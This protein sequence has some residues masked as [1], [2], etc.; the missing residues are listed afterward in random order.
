V[1]HGEQSPP[2]GISSFPAHHRLR[3]VCRAADR[4][5]E[6]GASRVAGFTSG[7]EQTSGI[8]RTKAFGARSGQDKFA[9]TNSGQRFEQL[10]H[11]RPQ[12][13]QAIRSRDGDD[14]ANPRGPNVLLELDVPIHR[15]HRFEP[16]QH[17]E[18]QQFA[19][20]LRRPT[21]VDDVLHVV[22]G[23]L[24]LERPGDTLIGQQ[25]HAPRSS[26]AQV[27]AQRPPFPG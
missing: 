4:G 3:A 21:H 10:V 1:R 26:P 24:T 2:G 9:S 18:L 20:P 17:H 11:E 7:P 22:P 13:F 12:L 25:P 15:E 6:Q 8:P 14:D 5:L 27:R 23:Q 19:I 16:L